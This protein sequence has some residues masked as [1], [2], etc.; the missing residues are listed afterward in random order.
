M[1]RTRMNKLK[2]LQERRAAITARI[3]EE[4]KKLREEEHRLDTRRKILAG[5]WAL[6][7]AARDNEFSATMM[8]ELRTFLVRDD[9]RALLGLPPLPEPAKPELA[10]PP[11]KIAS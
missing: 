7:K 11:Q 5:A 3:R 2:R 8:G 1:K 9:D 4:E 6:E 10:K